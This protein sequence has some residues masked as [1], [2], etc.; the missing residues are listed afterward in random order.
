VNLPYTHNVSLPYR[1]DVSLPYRHNVS[2]PYR[3][4]VSLPYRQDVSL[5]YRHDVSLPYR[6][7]VSLPYRHDVSLP[8][9]LSSPAVIVLDQQMSVREGF[10][11]CTDVRGLGYL[12]FRNA[13][14]CFNST[15]FSTTVLKTCVIKI[16]L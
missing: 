6:H 15:D 4:N 8:Y 10:L 3:H 5:P 1:H 14:T 11:I 16:L 12:L 2:L 9:R 7:D 13:F